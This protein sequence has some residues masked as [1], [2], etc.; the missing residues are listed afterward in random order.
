MVWQVKQQ[1]PVVEN[2]ANSYQRTC[3]KSKWQAILLGMRHAVGHEQDAI[4]D[5]LL[6]V[7]NISLRQIRDQCQAKPTLQTQWQIP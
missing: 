7:F 3:G 1:T 6:A 5:T 4:T 2:N